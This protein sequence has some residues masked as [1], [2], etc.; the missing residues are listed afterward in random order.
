VSIAGPM[1]DV[2]AWHMHVLLMRHCC[3]LHV[4]QVSVHS[5]GSPLRQSALQHSA[6]ILAVASVLSAN[7]QAIRGLV[8]EFINV[9]IFRCQT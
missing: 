3:E 5:T 2:T 9:F 8:A 7:N 4:V 6:V 1:A